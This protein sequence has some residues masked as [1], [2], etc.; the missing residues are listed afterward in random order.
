MLGHDPLIPA[1]A[2]KEHWCKVKAKS[3]LAKPPRAQAVYPRQCSID[4]K[5]GARQ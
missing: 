4:V 1:A 2:Q 5:L 3:S